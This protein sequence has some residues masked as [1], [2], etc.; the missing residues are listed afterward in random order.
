MRFA[1]AL[2]WWGYVLAFAAALFLA[3]LTYARLALPLSRG[4]RAVLIALRADRYRNRRLG[5]LVVISDGG[6]TA[7][8]EAGSGRRINAPLFAVGVG[9]AAAVRDREVINVT[10]GEPLFS[11]SSID[12]SV[13]A[14]SHGYGTT[15]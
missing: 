7:G 1:V 13:S 9:S 11:D 10:A 6:D 4:R 3:W 2:P 5:G 15:P 8:Q 12:L 14:V